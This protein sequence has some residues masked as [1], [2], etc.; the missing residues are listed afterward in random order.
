LGSCSHGTGPWP[1]HPLR[2]KRSRLRW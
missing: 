2:R 1:F